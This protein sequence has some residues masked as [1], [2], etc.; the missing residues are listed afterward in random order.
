[1]FNTLART[2]Q[3]ATRTENTLGDLP[4]RDRELPKDQKT[5][6]DHGWSSRRWVRMFESRHL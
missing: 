5:Q 3:V 2:F 6:R 1:M 4:P